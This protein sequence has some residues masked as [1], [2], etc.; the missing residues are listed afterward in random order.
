[1][2]F[3]RNITMPKLKRLIAWCHVCNKPIRPAESY[4]VCMQCN[5]FAHVSCGD[6]DENSENFLCNEEKS[7]IAEDWRRRHRRI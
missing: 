1:M 7:L 5:R 2:R 4:N 3:L 6:Q